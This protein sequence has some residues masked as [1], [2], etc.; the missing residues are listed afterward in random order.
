[1]KIYFMMIVSCFT[2]FFSGNDN[3]NDNSIIHKNSV[4]DT[5]IEALKQA[6]ENN[7][8]TKF[9][10]FFPD[11]YD[12]LVNFYGF[13]DNKG[14]SPLYSLYEVHINYLFDYE[15]KIDTK[16]FA[17]KIYEVAKNGVWDADA[18]GLFQSK[19]S[20][21]IISKPDIFLEILAMKPN[22][23]MKGFWHF[24]FDGSEKNDLQNK[25]RFNAIYK[26]IKPL[27]SKQAEI[28]NHEFKG[29]YK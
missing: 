11:S 24:V 10:Q 23:E 12:E 29:M 27:N 14:A 5:R 15:G 22:K 2:I 20:N 16:S 7:D 21:M 3:K 8:Y 17:T 6:F 13:D 1:M 26:K 19:L 28:L 18:V 9:F 4:I 25:E